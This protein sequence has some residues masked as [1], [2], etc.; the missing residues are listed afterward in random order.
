M[1]AAVRFGKARDKSAYLVAMR[2]RTARADDAHVDN[3]DKVVLTKPAK[4]VLA[5]ITP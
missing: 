3:L 2:F 1:I 4:P 5:S